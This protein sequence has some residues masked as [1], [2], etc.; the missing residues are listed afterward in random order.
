MLFRSTWDGLQAFA[1]SPQR[2]KRLVEMI[3]GESITA[4]IEGDGSVGIDALIRS[5]RAEETITIYT[6]RGAVRVN[7]LQVAR[8]VDRPRS[9]SFEGCEVPEGTSGVVAG[10]ADRFAVHGRIDD[11]HGLSGFIASNWETYKPR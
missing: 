4:E 9:W 7:I 11:R 5:M 3:V 6:N 8:A 1:S 2:C 10:D